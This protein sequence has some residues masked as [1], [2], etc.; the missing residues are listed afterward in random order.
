LKD[1]ERNKNNAG[2]TGSRLGTASALCH[3]A[4]T[5]IRMGKFDAA[6]TPLKDSMRIAQEVE[7]KAVLA[8]TLRERGRLDHEEGNY[9]EAAEKLEESL[10]LTREA[11]DKSAMASILL[12]LG[13]TQQYLHS[14]HKANNLYTE[15]VMAARET[16]DRGQMAA[17][18][19][20][21][22]Q[23]KVALGD[24]PE[25]LNLGEGGLA[26]ATEIDDKTLAGMMLKLLGAAHEGLGNRT[27]AAEMYRRAFTSLGGDRSLLSKVIG[28]FSKDESPLKSIVHDDLQRVQR[29]PVEAKEVAPPEATEAAVEAPAEEATTVEEE[30]APEPQTVQEEVPATEVEERETETSGEEENRANG[31]LS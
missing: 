10:K 25:A 21:Q 20:H 9:E 23:L 31:T 13:E 14:F 6:D 22:I 27:R 8:A 1:H 16:G 7:D 3:I 30:P 4:E 19:L 2:K 12:C 17:A 15:S 24:Y 11:G 18:M 5:C 29:K 28:F 26:I